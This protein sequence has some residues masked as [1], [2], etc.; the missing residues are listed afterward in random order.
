MDRI[1]RDSPVVLLD[2][3]VQVLALPDSDWLQ[4]P[5]RRVP[6]LAFAIAGNDRLPVRLAAVDDDTVWSAMTF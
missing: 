3:V 6:K 4:W 5:L 2:P 1:R